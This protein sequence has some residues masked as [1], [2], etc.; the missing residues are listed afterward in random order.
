VYFKPLFFRLNSKISL[1]K[2]KSFL[3]ITNFPTVEQAIT[4]LRITTRSS[5]ADSNSKNISVGDLK[6]MKTTKGK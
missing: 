6:I 3:L 4:K 1:N 2:V 5:F